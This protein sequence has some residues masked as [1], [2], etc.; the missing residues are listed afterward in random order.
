MKCTNDYLKELEAEYGIYKDPVDVKGLKLF[1][2][3]SRLQAAERLVWAL[4]PHE[5]E[6][7][8]DFVRASREAWRKSKGE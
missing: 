6:I 3:L 7:D 4:D 8:K 1:A 2:L 5:G